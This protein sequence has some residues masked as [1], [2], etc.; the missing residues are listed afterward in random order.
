M[1]WKPSRVRLR[2][3]F[4]TSTRFGDWRLQ[5]G[6]QSV[7]FSGLGTGIMKLSRLRGAARVG[8]VTMLA[9]MQAGCG[10]ISLGSFGGFGGSSP[11]VQQDAS[12]GPEIPGTIRSD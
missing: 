11:P 6:R 2:S 4:V 8:S 9:A 3:F 1:I 7:Q 10:S 12:L 5:R